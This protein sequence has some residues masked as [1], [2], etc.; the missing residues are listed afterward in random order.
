M[1]RT[2]IRYYS[3]RYELAG[4]LTPIYGHPI[5]VKF[6]NNI[7]ISCFNMRY[8][9]PNLPEMVAIGQA[10]PSGRNTSIFN[11]YQ[12]DPNQYMTGLKPL[13]KD[14]YFGNVLCEEKSLLLV[15][16][17]SR[18]HI[19]MFIFQDLYPNPKGR[20]VKTFIQHLT[21]KRPKEKGPSKDLARNTFDTSVKDD[22]K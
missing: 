9:S 5:D 10:T 2:H 3:G 20:D 15:H 17:E 7:K 11:L 14:W 21:G 18:D 19:S 1:S 16:W 8:G 4:S 13:M 6:K 12:R 22:N